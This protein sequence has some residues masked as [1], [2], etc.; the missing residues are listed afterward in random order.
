[1]EFP[2]NIDPILQ[3]EMTIYKNGE[4]PRLTDKFRNHELLNKLSTIVDEMGSASG[5][6]QGL[7]IPITTLNKLMQSKH[8]LYL[9][10][11]EPSN[12]GKDKS[13][14]VGI[15]KTGKKHLFLTD[16]T[17][18]MHEVTANCVLDFYVHESRQRS[19]YGKKL[20]EIML[21][22]EVRQPSLM[23]YDR[24]SPKLLG[25][26]NKHYNL[27]QPIKQANNYVVFSAFFNKEHSSQTS[28]HNSENTRTQVK[29][30]NPV[31]DNIVTKTPNKKD[32]YFPK[33]QPPQQRHRNCF[34]RYDTQSPEKKGRESKLQNL[35]AKNNHN[36]TVSS[37]YDK[38]YRQYPKSELFF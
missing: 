32:E 27:A 31:I 37:V 14:V 23:A 1:M 25:F 22:E 20:F 29:T 8:T 21:Q 4:V 5:R 16:M 17:G 30:N 18:R 36:W 7:Y 15:L 28:N 19:G 12:S 9:L 13:K 10:K 33:Y 11:E 3:G 38:Y 26:L 35:V 24:P 6:A 34:S 2:F